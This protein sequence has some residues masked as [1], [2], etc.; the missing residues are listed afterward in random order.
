[1]LNIESMNCKIGITRETLTSN[2]FEN[3]VVLI[4]KKMCQICL[5]IGIKMKICRM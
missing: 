3:V 2:M 4:E 5:D 1:M